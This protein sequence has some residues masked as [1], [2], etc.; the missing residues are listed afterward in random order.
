[1]VFLEI[2]MT[3][4]D[5]CNIGDI[6]KFINLYNYYAFDEYTIDIVSVVYY[7]II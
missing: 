6:G 1:M 7:K 3:S 4:G 5:F 2:S